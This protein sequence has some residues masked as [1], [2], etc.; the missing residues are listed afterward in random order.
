MAI[1]MITTPKPHIWLYGQRIHN[2]EMNLFSGRIDHAISLPSISTTKIGGVTQLDKDSIPIFFEE[3][4]V[5][6]TPQTSPRHEYERTKHKLSSLEFAGKD[7][8]HRL[9]VN[10]FAETYFTINGKDPVRSKA[11]LYNYKD[12]NDLV[13]INEATDPSH[14]APEENDINKLGFVIADSPT[15]HNLITIKAR[16]YQNGRASRIAVACIKICT[17]VDSMTFTNENLK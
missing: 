3:V 2:K 5:I 9:S 6:I 11:Y 4:R 17:R 8:P 1:D 15:G 7:S 10:Y 14:P 12:M 13:T 16:T